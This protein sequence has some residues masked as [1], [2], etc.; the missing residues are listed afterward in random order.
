MTYNL[1]HTLQKLHAEAGR[2]MKRN[3]AVHEPG[4]R[5]VRLKS[6]DEVAFRWES[7]SITT[8]RIIG[9]QKRGIAGPLCVFRLGEDVEVVTVQVD[10]MREG[11]RCD[12]CVL[13]DYPVLPLLWLSVS[14]RWGYD[15]CN[16]K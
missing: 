15:I 1:I 2:Y 13:L 9:F 12:V 16:G 11:R 6:K 14:T 8:N 4:A 3:M 5:V 7:S 10:W